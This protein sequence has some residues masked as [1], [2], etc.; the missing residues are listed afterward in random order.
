MLSATR[1]ERRMAARAEDI[2][3]WVEIR[4]QQIAAGQTGDYSRD[5]IH[6]GD[7]V[8]YRG[9]WFTVRRA[10]PKTVSIPSIVGGSWTDTIGYHKLTGHRPASTSR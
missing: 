1:K 6:P 3:Y 10:N 5:T 9:Q 7:Q 4:R 8:H 2:A